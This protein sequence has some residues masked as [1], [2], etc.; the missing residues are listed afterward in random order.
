MNF[1]PDLLEAESSVRLELEDFFQGS[2]TG[3]PLQDCCFNLL[4]IVKDDIQ[5]IGVNSDVLFT[6]L[7]SL[8][9]VRNLV[10]EQLLS[11]IHI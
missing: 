9:W 7:E 11:L 4:S 2:I 1:L 3:A 5:K 10:W 6:S 8:E